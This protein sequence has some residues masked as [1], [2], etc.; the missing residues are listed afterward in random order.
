MINENLIYDAQSIL[1]H[2]HQ[3]W[4]KACRELFIK[5]E[6]E[7][8]ARSA[9]RANAYKSACDILLAAVRGDK[10]ILKEFDYYAD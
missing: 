2:R 4:E 6:T 7:A 1:H 5:G 8:G 9:A 3:Y 10:E